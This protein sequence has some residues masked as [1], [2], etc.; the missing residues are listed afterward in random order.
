MRRRRIKKK[1]R[2]IDIYLSVERMIG[3]PGETV[4]DPK[5]ER[6]DKK[7]LKDT[8][9]RQIKIFLHAARAKIIMR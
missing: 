9:L 1:R 6:S 4:F 3:R 8:H 7:D 5:S 2:E